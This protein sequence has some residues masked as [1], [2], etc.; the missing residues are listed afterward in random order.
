MIF[1]SYGF[2]YLQIFYSEY[3][4]LSS[5]EGGK[6]FSE[7]LVPCLSWFIVVENKVSQRMFFSESEAL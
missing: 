2:F 4:I 5:G 1:S 6:V 3:I 7:R